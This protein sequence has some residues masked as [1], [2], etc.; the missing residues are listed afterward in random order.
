M[1]G[2]GLRELIYKKEAYGIGSSHIIECLHYDGGNLSQG[3]RIVYYEDGTI[4]QHGF[5]KDS[6]WFG[7]H[8][9]YYS[10]SGLILE[11]YYSIRNPG[12][13]ITEEEYRGELFL[14][15]MGEIERPEFFY[16]L[17]YYRV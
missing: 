8:Y 13:L 12:E 1:R 16:L 4:H 2:T 9:M 7:K 11:E 17:K 14:F 15:R 3:E 6:S 10:V 5:C